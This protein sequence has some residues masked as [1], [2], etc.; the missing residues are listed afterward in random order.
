VVYAVLLAL[1]LVGLTTM[2]FAASPGPGQTGQEAVQKDWGPHHTFGLRLNLT[3][4][5]KEK[6]KELV[7]RFRPGTHD[8]KYDIAIKRLELRKL[9]TDPKTDSAVLLAKEKELNGLRLKLMDRRAE[10]KVEWRNILAPEQ[11]AMLDRID[12][13]HRHEWHHRGHHP[14]G[15]ERGPMG[16]PGQSGA[17]PMG[18]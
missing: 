18:E 2:V 5:Q 17:A 13:H 14:W 6:M 7:K 8:L 4:A 3:E 15:P 11:I 9:F 10:M 1:V 12:R 16:G